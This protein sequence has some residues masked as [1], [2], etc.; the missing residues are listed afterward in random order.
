M[1][2]PWKKMNALTGSLCTVCKMK[3]LRRSACVRVCLCVCVY[4]SACFS[5]KTTHR[6]SVKFGVRL[7]TLKVIRKI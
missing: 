7:S 4:P 3:I 1:L 5:L 2:F 6:I